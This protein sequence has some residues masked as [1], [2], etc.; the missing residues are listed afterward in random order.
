MSAYRKLLWIALLS[1]TPLELIAQLPSPGLSADQLRNLADKAKTAGDLQAESNYICQAAATDGKKYAKRCE[2]DKLN[3]TKI[4][5][6]FRAD[7][8]VAK[9]EIARQDYPGAIRDLTK[10]TFGPN[11]I[12]AQQI[13]QDALVLAGRIPQNQMS[14]I[15]LEAGRH[16]FQRGDFDRA[17]ALLIHV[18]DSPY[19]ANAQQIR[20]LIHLYRDTMSQAG[21]LVHNGDYRGAAKKY[22][23][24]ISI[25]SNGPG[26]PEDR[27][28]ELDKLLP[29]EQNKPSPPSAPAAS[30][31][32]SQSAVSALPTGKIAVL[33]ANAHRF[34]NEKQ[35]KRALASYQSIL[36]LDPKQADALAGQKR[37]LDSL[38]QDPQA[39]ESKL[40]EALQDFYAS[41]F[42]DANDKLRAYLQAGTGR[43]QGAAHFYLGCNL[44]TETILR[45][46]DNSNHE[47]ELLQEA[48]RQFVL[49]RKLRYVPDPMFVS[50][51][52][53]AQWN[54]TRE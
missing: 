25:Q 43:H 39:L 15:A 49:A 12:E 42:S 24:A 31:S 46:S 26:Q 38:K 28:R 45:E 9:T 51:K 19:Q 13:L 17:E 27:L 1:F 34:E 20:G 29:S 52:L 8:D 53:L 5:A 44:V 41:R 18:S 33:L 22:Q 48:N 3:L 54:Q 47:S 36:V 14:P 30:A 2:K 21:V 50:P 35:L 7:L 4:L 10:I 16:A 32:T 37:I 40:V 6:Q 11:R 23:L